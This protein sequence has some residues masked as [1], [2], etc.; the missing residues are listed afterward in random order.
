MGFFRP[1]FECLGALYVVFYAAS[2][3][4]NNS[5]SHHFLEIL[6]GP[7]KAFK[8]ASIL[9]SSASHFDST[10][11]SEYLCFDHQVQA[12]WPSAIA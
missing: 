10:V 2:V 9:V 4:S 8:R 7:T 11:A 3:C 5:L 6:C 1:V 12:Q